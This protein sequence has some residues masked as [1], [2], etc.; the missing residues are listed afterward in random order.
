MAGKK[1]RG[2]QHA[3]RVERD[4]HADL[5]A[6]LAPHTGMAGLCVGDLPAGDD[7][8]R[9]DCEVW[10]Y[11]RRRATGRKFELKGSGMLAG[12]GEKKQFGA[13]GKD[14]PTLLEQCRASNSEVTRKEREGRKG[15]E[16]T[17]ESS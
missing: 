4:M 6:A 9:F 10:R 11:L 15:R 16:L 17:L 14:A 7:L 8:A 1:G 12:Q 5:K 13:H 3:K 2:W